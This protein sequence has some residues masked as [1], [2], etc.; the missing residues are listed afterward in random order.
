MLGPRQAESLLS[1]SFHLERGQ[2]I[3]KVLSDDDA[4]TAEAGEGMGEA[5]GLLWSRWSGKASRRRQ[6][7]ED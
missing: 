1:Q 5:G 6:L 7:R 3:N 4:K 2:A